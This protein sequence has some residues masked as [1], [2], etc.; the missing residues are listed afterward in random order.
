MFTS[1]FLA[2]QSPGLYFRS[3][4][5]PRRPISQA[6]NFPQTKPPLPQQHPRS[7]STEP[8]DIFSDALRIRRR[9]ERSNH[10]KWGFVIYRT[11]YGDNE[12]WERCK[13]IIIDRTRW[14]I[15]ESEAPELLQSLKWTFFEDC[16][17]FEGATTCMLRRHFKSWAKANWRLEQ[18]RG[19]TDSGQR[20]QFF[21]RVDRDVL[22]SIIHA[23]GVGEKLPWLEAGHI[24]LV[25]ALWRSQLERV[26]TDTE[27][28]DMPDL[29]FEPV[30][31]C[32][33]EDVGWM[34]VPAERIGLEMYSTFCEHNVWYIYYERPPA[35]AW[36]A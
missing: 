3:I 5:K 8:F 36:E 19:R 2:R 6:I 20:Y 30:E 25:D 11:T 24:D 14:Q 15:R 33:E 32:R 23:P 18:P 1:T 9:L 27:E 35:M 10:D 28:I 7:V 16:Q 13:E 17:A 21:L 34:R 12:A 22:E 26:D 4:L 29:D 31:G